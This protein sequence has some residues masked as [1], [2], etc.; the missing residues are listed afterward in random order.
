VIGYYVHHHGSGHRHRAL[1]IARHLGDGITLLGSLGSSADV[2][3]P[4]VELPRDDRPA[5]TLGADVTAGGAL[6]WAPLRHA[7]QQARAT[8]LTRWLVDNQARLLVSDV[9]V[10]AVLLAR[11]LSVPPVAVALRGDRRD[12]VHASGYDAAVRI[13]A[14]W[15][16]A[17]QQD[18]PRRWLAKTTWT[19]MISRF[20]GRARHVEPCGHPGRCVVLLL[21]RGGHGMRGQDL[22]EAGAVSDT[23]WHVLGAIGATAVTATI[24]MAGTVADPWPLLCGADVVVAAAGD[25]AIADV[26]AARVPLVAVPQDRPFGEQVEHV[27]V[28]AERQLCVPAAPWPTRE[29]W[30][31][32]LASA[33]EF[34]GYRWAEVSDGLGAQRAA[35]LL[36]DLA[37]P[38]VGCGTVA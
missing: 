22:T 16:R 17:T 11:L 35:T 1:S 27:R 24:L 25:A 37:S 32:L 23:H 29:Q 19:G 4:Y 2:A 15:T 10:E 12:R 28:L 6:H 30:P 7:G 3:A 26:A 8:A 18:W 13:L 9:S 33:Q 14:P 5:P 21:G 36:S 31:Q 34:D 38:P 20:D